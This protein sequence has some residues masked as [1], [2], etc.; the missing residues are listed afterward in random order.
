MRFEAASLVGDSVA[1]PQRCYI[2]KHRWRTNDAAGSAMPLAAHD[3]VSIT[4]ANYV[5]LD[6]NE[7]PSEFI[8]TR[9][10]LSLIA[11]GLVVLVGS[12]LVMRWRNHRMIP[13]LPE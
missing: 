9:A 12:P 3:A 7:V 2:N 13:N 1:A 5:A 6:A 11:L 8:V 10:G 4:D